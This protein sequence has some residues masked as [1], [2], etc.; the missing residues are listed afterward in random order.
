MSERETTAGAHSLFS[1]Q[2]TAASSVQSAQGLAQ[3]VQAAMF[4]AAER[5]AIEFQ[6]RWYTWGELRQVF[7]GL[8]AALA[9][10]GCQSGAAIAFI[11]R[12][13]PSAAA[14]LLGLLGRGSF[15]RMIYAFQSSSAIARDVER[16]R[17][18][19]VVAAEEDFTPELRAVLESR[20]VAAVALGEME[21]LW[22]GPVRETRPAP[23]TAQVLS[24]AV[25]N[26]RA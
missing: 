4:G 24:F 16:V 13:R 5:P 8:V 9:S 2:D 10:S 7:D 14:A 26:T 19:A 3:R 11:P 21:A 15:V 6:G 18:A 20:G 22:C 17:P 12:N 23:S 1:S 25:A